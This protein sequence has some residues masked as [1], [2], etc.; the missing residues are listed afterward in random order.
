M[1]AHEIGRALVEE[2]LPLHVER[3]VERL[4]E[5]HVGE[6]AQGLV[7]VGDHRREHGVGEPAQRGVGAGAAQIDVPPG[8]AEI[9]GEVARV[10]AIEEAEV[11]HAADDGEAP[12]PVAEAERLR[13]GDDPHR[14]GPIEVGVGAVVA[15]RRQPVLLAEA[16]DL[17][18]AP[19]QRLQP[20]RR[21][22][23]AHHVVDVAPRLEEIELTEPRLGEVARRAAPH[24]RGHKRE[25]QERDDLPEDPVAA[26]AG[27][28]GRE[29]LA[30]F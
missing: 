1:I 6:L 10:V 3:G 12:G 9:V 25:R 30:S 4:V 15:G 16:L 13:G 17:V 8:A 29:H 7:A 11:R 20:R 27:R 24:E 18:D 2:R 14:D 23:I 22:A 28:R 21:P 19:E 26:T 5:H